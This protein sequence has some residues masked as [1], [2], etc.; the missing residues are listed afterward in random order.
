MKNINWYYSI[1]ISFFFSKFIFVFNKSESIIQVFLFISAWFVDTLTM[2]LWCTRIV[3][4][5]LSIKKEECSRT[6][7]VVVTHGHFL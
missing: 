4:K 3:S 6:L 1:V 5:V 7:F 2:Q